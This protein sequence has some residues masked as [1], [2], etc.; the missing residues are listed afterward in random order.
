MTDLTLPPDVSAALERAAKRARTTPARLA[1]RAILAY[2]E[3]MADAK[4]VKHAL[5]QG[6]KAIPWSEVKRRHGLGG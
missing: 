2:L 1:R 5:A 4:A 6:A 3:E